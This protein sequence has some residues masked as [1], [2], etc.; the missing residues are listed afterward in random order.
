M[1][2]PTIFA[3]YAKPANAQRSYPVPYMLHGEMLF[4]ICINPYRSEWQITRRSR[5]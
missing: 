4:D 5:S 3:G 2:E 1:T